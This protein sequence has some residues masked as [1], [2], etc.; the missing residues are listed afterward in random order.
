MIASTTTTASTLDGTKDLTVDNNDGP[1]GCYMTFEP[2]SGGRLMILYSR[3]EIP[4]NS[5]GFWCAGPGRTIQDFKF[6]Q[7]G[8]WSELIKG[9]AGGDQ[10]RRKYYSGWCQFIKMAKAMNGY[11][12]KF[13]N[14]IQGVEV[15]VVAYHSATSQPYELDLDEGLVEVG[16]F[17]AISV[18]PKHNTTFRG[19]KSINL[20]NFLELGNLAGAST[21]LN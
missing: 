6:K 21:K 16:D 10:N 11:V 9:I 17:D 1:E 5:I 8:G 12:I 3:G 4:M 19:I 2:S 7:A 15:D 14:C 20:N 13:P 18:I